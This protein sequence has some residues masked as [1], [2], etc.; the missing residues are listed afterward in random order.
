MI[1]NKKKLQKEEVVS[2]CLK[3]Y[4]QEIN[5]DGVDEK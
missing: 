5:I 1:Y 3:F 2:F 4:K